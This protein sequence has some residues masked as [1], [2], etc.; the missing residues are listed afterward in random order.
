[1]PVPT[2]SFLLGLVVLGYLFTFV[3]FAVLRIV[4]GVSIQRLG[5]SGFRRI[6]FTLRNG[7]KINIRGVGLS[8][9]RP[10]FALPT[11]CSLVI[12]ELV[13]TVDLNKL[14][15]HSRSKSAPF[16]KANGTTA[17]QDKTQAA[18]D[19]EDDDIGRG[20]LWRRLTDI[21]EKIKRLH[22]KINWIRLVDLL[23]TAITLDLV[24][25][26]TVRIERVMLSVDTRS[27]TVDRSRLFQHHRTKPDTQTPAEWKSLVR[28]ILFTPDGRESTEILD[29][30]TINIHGMLHNELQ[31]LRDASI[32]LKLGRLNIPY[33]DIV[34]AKK[35]ADLLRGRYAQP[36]AQAPSATD[37]VANALQGLEPSQIRQDR[38]M[39]NVSD[40]RAFVASILRGIQEVQFAVGFF[41]LSR[42]VDVKTES[43]KDVFFNLAMTEMGLDI[44][45]LDP[46]SPAHRMYF[47][48]RDVAHQGLLTAISISAGFDDGHEHPERMC[49]IPMITATVKTTLPSRT[50]NYSDGRDAVERNANILYANLVC[51]SP[52][53]DLDPKHLPLV[54]EL[55]K[56][57]SQPATS[58]HT[59][60]QSRH[61]LISQLL[62]KAHIKL[63]VQEPVIRVSLPPMDKANATNDD[64]DLLISSVSSIAIELESSHA[65]QGATNY[66]LG[67]HYRHVRHQLYYQTSAGDRHDLLRSDTVEVQVDINA[68]PDASVVVSGRLQTFTFF[69][70]RPDI[71][72]GVR[73]IV[74]QLRKNVLRRHD[75]EQKPKPSF[76]RTIPSWLQQSRIE[77]S[78]FALEIAGVD[79]SISTDTRGFALQLGSWS[80]EYNAQRDKKPDMF[81]R[82]GSISKAAPTKEQRS[83]T[84]SPR[85]R[86]FTMADGRRLT[87][88]FQNLEGLIVD[89]FETSGVDTFLS[90]PRF[91]VAFSTTTDSNG[92]LL[93]VNS[94]ARN[95]LLDYSLYHQFSVG[96][97]IMVLRKTFQDPEKKPR[98]RETAASIKPRGLQIPGQMLTMDDVA[99]HEITTI[100]FKSDLIQV[101]AR[102]PADPPM[103]LQIFGVECGRHRYGIPFARARLCRLYVQ[104]PRTKGAWSRIVSIRV[105][106]MDLREI[107]RKVGKSHVA[108]KSI[109]V[110]AEGIRFTVPHSLVVHDIFDNVINVI[111]ANKQML[112]HFKTG[113]NED[114]LMKEPEGPKN[115]P[116]IN[117]RTQMCVLHVEDSTFEWKLTAIY[118]AG[119]LE[120]K[121][122]LA[123]EEA[124]ALKEKWLARGKKRGRSNLRAQS[125][126]PD[127]RRA[128]SKSKTRQPNAAARGSQSTQPTSKWS[129][130][131]SQRESRRKMR[132]DAE[133][134]CG[135]SDTS[136]CTSEKARERLDILNAQ[137]WKNRIDRVLDFQTKAVSEIRNVMWGVDDMPEDTDQQE[138]ILAL[139]SRP[140]LLLVTISDLNITVDKPS[141]PVNEYAKFLH[142]VGKG[143][144]KEMKYGLLIP[145]N[146]HITMGEARFQLR[147][148]PLPLLH[149]P[150]L[151]HGQSPRTPSLSVRTD[152][153]IAEE[154]RDVES[155]RHVTVEVVPPKKTASGNGYTIDVRRTIS[156][157]KTYSD[158]K[159][160][161]NTSRATRITWGTSYQPG[162][163]D[164]MQV[165]EGFT[166]PPADPSDRV[167]FWDKIRLSFH[168]RINVAWKGDGD[169]HLAL[170]GSRDPYVV[171]GQ[172]AGLVMVWRNDVRWNIAQ[173]KDPREFMTVSSAEY[174]LAVPNF[175]SFARRIQDPD[176]GDDG[177]SASSSISQRRD[178]TFKKVVMKLSGK[179][180]WVGGMM[181]ERELNNE[182]RSFDFKPH[183][184]VVL[185]HPDYAK[186][187]PGREYDA[188]HG[189]RSRHI[190]MSV[191]VSAPHD[192]QWSVTNLQP[193]NNYNAIHLTPR[194]F[195]HFFSWWSMF[196]GVMSLPIRQGPLFGSTDHK[197]G[198]KLGR[199][200][201]TFKYNVLLSPL[202]ISH[203]YK[204]KDAEDYQ[205][206]VVS[207]TGLKAKLDSFML[208]MHQRRE[209]F[210]LQGHQGAQSK[211]SSGMKIN[212][213]QLD[214]IHADLRAL[215]ASITGT[216][217]EDIEKANE[218]TLASLYGQLPSVDM[219]KFTIP[220]NDFTW[221]DMDDFVELDWILPAET[222][223]QTKILPLAYAPRFTYFRNTDHG[224]DIAG[225]PTRS[226]PFGDEPTHDCVMSAKNDPRRVQAELI[227][228]RI[229]KLKE[230]KLHNARAIGE[231]ELKVIQNIESENSQER[232]ML[233]ALR[234]HG[235][236][237]QKKFDFLES[238]LN[239]LY[240]R[241]E[242]DDPAAVPDLET[243]EAFFEAHESAKTTMFEHATDAAPLGDYTSD[244]NN[245][246]IVHNAQ[247]KWNNSLRNTILRYIHQNGQRRGFVYYM[248][249]R[250]VK[251]ILDII[252]E[253]RKAEENEHSQRKKAFS[254]DQGMWSPDAVD[255]E[256]T[257]QDRIDELLK[258][259]RS[260][261]TADD[262]P[263]HDAEKTTT[264]DGPKDD[265]AVDFAALNTYQFRLIAPQV[266]LQSEKNPKA[267]V[268]VSAKGMQLKVVQIMD[269]NRVSD[270]VSGLVQRRFTAAADSLQMF[271]TT[272]KSFATEHLHMYSANR[273]GNKSGSYWPPW[274]PMEMIVE[275][276]TNPY[277]FN[278]VVQRTSASLRYD[279]YNTLRLKYNDDVSGGEP[280]TA[281]SAEEAE[282]RMDHVWLEFPQ[283]RAICDSAQYYA[284]YMIVTELL[285]Y[286]EPLEKTRTERLE[287]ILLASD[288]SDLSGAPGMVSK[289]QER[290]RQLEEIK[291][292]FQVNEKYLDRQGWKDR[293]AIDQDLANCEDELFFMMK[294][295]TTAQQRNEDRREQA[296]V[297]GMMHLN[298]SANEIAW[299]LIR[300]KGESLVELQLRD[301]AFN[302]THNNDG[303][304]YNMVEIG[305]INGYNLLRDAIYPQIIAPFVDESRGLYEQRHGSMLR[306]QWLMLEAIAGI[307][308]VDY[309]EVDLVPLKLQVE[310]DVA[311]KLFEYIF[312][313]VGGSAFEGGG[314]SPFMAKHAP[315]PTDADEDSDDNG[316]GMPADEES[317]SVDPHPHGLAS[318]EQRLKPT[319]HLQ[320]K[321]KKA[322]GKG[323]GIS[324]GTNQGTA[325]KARNQSLA[326]QGNASTS[327]LP[328]PARRS[329]EQSLQKPKAG[330]DGDKGK[331]GGLQGKKAIDKK[332]EPDDLTQMVNRAS[333]YMTLAFV[334]IPSMVLC[335]SYKG[336]GKRNIEDVHDLVFRLPTLEYRNKT[337]SNLDLALQL[338]KDIVR[339]LISHAGAIVS[340]KFSHHKPSRM[341]QSR[342]REIANKSSFMSPNASKAKLDSDSNG[343]RD[344]SP[345]GRPSMASGRPG[346]LNRTLSDT[347]TPSTTSIADIN[348]GEPPG[349]LDG[350]VEA[351]PTTPQRPS[352]FRTAASTTDGE[353][354][355]PRTASITRHISGLGERLRQRQTDSN[356]VEDAE[357]NKRKSK[358]LLGGQ[359]LLGKLRD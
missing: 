88:H 75:E 352:L 283:F 73:Q 303:S 185:K 60:H 224:G 216:S 309:F 112:H 53:V 119:L 232:E 356:G 228:K 172:G 285:L 256:T 121:Q 9:H 271:V 339:A 160:E 31:G 94:H 182:S 43:G 25:V 71:C 49:Y 237:L 106:R 275:F 300:E 259:G 351:R 220:D 1:M 153:V 207:A 292:Q 316:M 215:S 254:A 243:S 181:F 129:P 223:P 34:H 41:G 157:V 327:N 110:V 143:M 164:A 7:V 274:V 159:V 98:P 342:L 10:T 355:R 240:Q 137:S 51:T 281:E 253:R 111:K 35:S 263:I 184:D 20:R 353:T 210:D 357:E 337:W 264:N 349:A 162:I 178:A 266:Q 64:Y 33:D 261:V 52:S 123:R 163:Q 152:F 325:D 69:L 80:S 86:L 87:V 230:Q 245:R 199:H 169:V 68:I 247:I 217:T 102:M 63:S 258:D 333:N 149:V 104:M 92:P 322:D 89:S 272:S 226:S 312:P 233:A 109:D 155:Q 347:S 57:R 346:T 141:F 359:K 317:S 136:H 171:T 213:A 314:F 144:P 15:A 132:Y 202:Y 18:Q 95:V 225:D 99:R 101:K 251:F 277:G 334:K 248:S 302:R 331:R 45:R 66:S 268:L 332:Q 32:A 161:I 147:D 114:V 115:V 2:A 78:D 177:G 65:A 284:M 165:L 81:T 269:R 231:Q 148:Y 46:K 76:L 133:G 255:D 278:R 14:A 183:Y 67:T 236:Q 93:H 108:E 24:G 91:E 4:T 286:S 58:G 294:A 260:F 22:S 289:L 241:L 77:G 200:I 204:H 126:H 345:V 55:L 244:F 138:Q 330:A 296:D 293:I 79:E 297:A 82:R 5:F 321:Q 279:K 125:A 117:L 205:E 304:D 146:L 280:A 288:F 151:A 145:M 74:A 320:G 242:D 246:F 343:T 173:S 257:I 84:P 311:K 319:L 190:H 326:Q 211:Q 167:G 50:V 131:D 222:D 262:P 180:Q 44:L 328:G 238:M 350:Q 118:R 315:T 323:L 150:S 329:S 219:S 203:V 307:P 97:A 29:Y 96:V 221:I 265:I 8:I 295:I 196:S 212:Q 291:M 47:S 100:D 56:Q 120:Q 305:G 276:Q 270:D 335:L 59:Q 40:S 128:R 122:R 158:M 348:S 28:S 308:V 168:S 54:R 235:E 142:D 299:H 336:H 273:Y 189:F 21:K 287:K 318:L 239:T 174:V 179:V 324:S 234:A 27:K 156:P 209:Y 301:A 36:H 214:F 39:Q 170:K 192:R 306:V 42:K 26:G 12:T 107:N 116:K 19:A 175:S 193:S 48:T 313:G 166:K 198:K 290:I 197:K 11:W 354:S 176:E 218:A 252:D 124:F 154:F 140:S 249:R 23:A 61:Q 139:N 191:A 229:D 127:D 134:K 194:F 105:L 338:K 186:A 341:Q 206:N 227:E 103:M 13:V 282:R 208:D 38:L 113:T 250:A 298:M 6:A 130:P 135:L 83:R 17:E 344:S 90:V 201:A 358:L 3:V 340:N 188:Y 70:V 62:P 267:A 37:S 30:A 310:R 85:R 72:E 16:A 195:S 187:P